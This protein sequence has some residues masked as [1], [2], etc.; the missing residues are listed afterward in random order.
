MTGLVATGPG[1]GYEVDTVL[2]F[3]LNWTSNVFRIRSIR[4]LPRS[5][6]PRA[7]SLGSVKAVYR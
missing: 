4:E 2:Q 3:D 7:A 1:E 6:G 5:G